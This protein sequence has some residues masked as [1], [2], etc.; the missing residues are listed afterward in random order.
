[1]GLTGALTSVYRWVAVQKL[2]VTLYKH[3]TDATYI[4]E[5]LDVHGVFSSV[6]SH[7]DLSGEMSRLH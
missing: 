5:V 3:T 4:V 1:M 7:Q 6:E 2:P